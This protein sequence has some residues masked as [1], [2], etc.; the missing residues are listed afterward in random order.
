MCDISDIEDSPIATSITN[1]EQN[2]IATHVN[3]VFDYS[4]DYL[5][6]ELQSIADGRYLSGVL[7]IQVE[8]SYG[9]LPWYPIELIKDEDQH[10]VE[11]YVLSNDLGVVCNGIHKIWVC[12]F[13]RSIK[14][15][16]CLRCTDNLCLKQ[17]RLIRGHRTKID[18]RVA[19]LKLLISLRGLIMWLLVDVRRDNLN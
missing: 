13:I 12:I 10:T 4:D 15:T 11:K 1:S 19:M 3:T 5:E 9:E 16:L 6:A 2:N 17:P 8:Y 14:R 18:V 7:D